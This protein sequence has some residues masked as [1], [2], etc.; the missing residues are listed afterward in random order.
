VTSHWKNDQ[1][2]PT[3]VE[4][5]TESHV[6]SNDFKES[7]VRTH[8]GVELALEQSHVAYVKIES[9]MTILYYP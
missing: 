6:G 2:K 1:C 9:A 8:F 3:T 7:V 5:V 4:G